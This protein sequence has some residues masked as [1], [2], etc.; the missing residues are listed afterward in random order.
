MIKALGAC[1]MDSGGDAILN[2]A[3]TDEDIKKGN[4]I[5]WGEG[6]RTGTRETAAVYVFRECEREVRD[7]KDNEQMEGRMEPYGREKTE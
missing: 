3:G 1:V 6:P 4:V 2:T 7:A 5:A